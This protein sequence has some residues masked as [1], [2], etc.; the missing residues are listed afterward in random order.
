[1]TSNN[2]EDKMDKIEDTKQDL[3]RRVNVRRDRARK[4]VPAEEEDD[5]DASASNAVQG[6]GSQSHQIRA[7][8]GYDNADLADFFNDFREDIKRVEENEAKDDGRRRT[9]YNRTR[10][11]HRSRRT[12]SAPKT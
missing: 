8:V 2:S 12:T 3:N 4:K 11:S 10:T 9:S 7:K 6:S 1:M 5:I